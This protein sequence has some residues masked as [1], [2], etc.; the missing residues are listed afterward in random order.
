LLTGGSVVLGGRTI[1]LKSDGK[2]PTEDVLQPLLAV[3]A[4]LRGGRAGD[5]RLVKEQA[6]PGDVPSKSDSKLLSV[7]RTFWGALPGVVRS[8]SRSLV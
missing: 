2:D 3:E 8:S 4:E 5:A 7:S 1:T 6:E